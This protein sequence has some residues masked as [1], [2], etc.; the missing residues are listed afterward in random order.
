VSRD[1]TGRKA[2]GRQK[3]TSR[4]SLKRVLESNEITWP[5]FLCGLLVISR[6]LYRARYLYEWDSVQ[7][8]LSIKKFDI[9][10]HQ[11]HPPGYIL[12]VAVIKLANFIVNDPNLSIIFSNILF[13]IITIIV[14]FKLCQLFFRNNHIALLTTLLLVVN[15]IFWFYGSTATI[16][17]TEALISTLVGYAFF[18]SLSSPGLRI[19]LFSTFL[20]GFLG[21]F[22][23]TSILLLAPLW[24]YISICKIRNIKDFIKTI[25]LLIISISTWAIPTIINTGG[26]DNYLNVSRGLTGSSSEKVNTFFGDYINYLIVNFSN[27]SI[28]FLQGITPIGL[29]VIFLA[30]IYHLGEPGF[31]GFL[32]KKA[33][34]LL[35]WIA[36]SFIFYLLYL[37]KPGYLLTII[38][39]LLILFSWSIGKITSKIKDAK[40]KKILGD[41]LYYSTLVLSVIWFVWPSSE[42]GIPQKINTPLYIT[43]PPM[44]DYNWD[45]SA[46]EIRQ[47]DFIQKATYDFLRNH[48]EYDESNS[49]IFSAGGYP[50][51]RHLMYY[52]PEYTIYW[53]VDKSISGIPAFNSEYYL[54]KY[55]EVSSYSGLPFWVQG[56]RSSEIPVEL[57]DKI[58]ICI[59]ILGEK[60]IMHMKL[61]SESVYESTNLP[62]AE[63]ILIN[64]CKKNSDLG[65]F[66]IH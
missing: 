20:L 10:W 55:F 32:K 42:S 40:K 21:G 19:F 50:T 33:V 8:A 41:G 29:G 59:W 16:Y 36:P 60:T 35:L 54:A 58:N 56:A 52:L 49:V 31:K 14:F 37:E 15:P 48:I 11:P 23:Q 63:P 44:S 22:R 7:F 65:N 18:R 64:D 61:K 62:N 2:I 26:L 38:P 45:I 66:T 25:A 57:N 28:W 5:I 17:T 27:F 46:R 47:K 51:W 34:F 4:N 43:E 13:G 9:T 3:M 1:R 30:I 24:I 53:L 39:P 12:Y 6:Y